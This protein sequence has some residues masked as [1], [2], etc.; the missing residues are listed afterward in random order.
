MWWF[1]GL[2]R[3]LSGV[4]EYMVVVDLNLCFMMVEFSGLIFL[5]YYFYYL[6]W[7]GGSCFLGISWYS[8]VF[9]L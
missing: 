1:K 6:L 3:V 5:L 7:V 2:R 9:V 4:R 8:F